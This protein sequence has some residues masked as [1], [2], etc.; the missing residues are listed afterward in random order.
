MEAA[1][2]FVK[3]FSKLTSPG[4]AF[5]LAAIDMETDNHRKLE[6]GNATAA[7]S[8]GEAAAAAAAV[9]QLFEA[10]VSSYGRHSPELWV[11]YALYEAAHDG[12]GG[13]VYWRATKALAD[14]DDFIALYQERMRAVE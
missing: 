13:L 7:T 4:E 2:K 8:G 3:R 5:F 12:S 14:P 6:D 1:R 9:R 10:A 11:Q